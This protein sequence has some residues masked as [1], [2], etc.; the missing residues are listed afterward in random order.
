VTTQRFVEGDVRACYEFLAHC[1]RGVSEIRVIAPGRG[2]VGIGYFDNAD[3]FLRACAD[4]TGVGN[5]YVGIQPRPWEFLAQA[6]NRLERL[7]SG[8]RDEDIQW[9]S[10]IVIDIDPIRPK[11][12]AATSDELA[13][14]IACGDRI[15][16]WLASKGFQRPVRNMSGNGCQLWFAVPPTMITDEQRP[17]IRERLKLFEARLRDKF[18]GDGVAIDSIYNFSRIIKVIGTLSVKGE[19]TAE[20]PHRVSHSLDAFERRE[21]LELLEAIFRIPLPASSPSPSAEESAVTVRTADQL[22]PKLQALLSSKTR[23]R[24]LFEGRGKTAIGSDGTPL[25]TSSSGY[26]YSLALKLAQ[27]GI[28]DPDELA[29]VLWHRP[30]GEA[31]AKGLSYIERT[32]RHALEVAGAKRALATVAGDGSEENQLPLIQ[33]NNRQPR[34]ITIDARYAFVAGNARRIQEAPTHGLQSGGLPPM[35]LRGGHIV[36]LV[37]DGD[38][39]PELAET[40]DTAMLG[41]LWRDA[42]WINVTEGE[43]MATFP[44]RDIARDLVTF[45]DPSIPR[46]DIVLSTPVFGK[47]GTLITAPG[48]HA[49][50]ALWLEP[51]EGLQV[52]ELEREPTPEQVSHARQL[53]TEHLFVD[54]PFVDQADRAHG[55]AALLLPFVRRMIAGSTPLHLIEA[56]AVGSG[57]SLLCQLISIVATGRVLDASTLPGDEEEVRKTLTAELAKGSP[58]IL[59]DNAKERKVLD[60]SALASVLTAPTWRC[61]IL[62][63]SEIVIL[64]NSAMWMLTGNNPRLSVELTRRCVRIRIDPKR[65]RAWQRTGFKHDPITEWAAAHRAELVHAVLTLGQAWVAAGKPLAKQ[66]LGSFE[67][68]SAVMG[69]ILEVIGVPGFLGNL[70]DMYAE[71]DADGEMWR[72]FIS[73]WWESFGDEE[74]RVNELN[75]LCEQKNLM[76]PIRGDGAERAQQT[77]LGRALQ[78]ARD[79]VFDDVCLE[80]HRDKH[81]GRHYRLVP[82]TAEVES[83]N[84]SVDPWE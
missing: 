19:D 79:R 30:N 54:F 33:L 21:D 73:A 59:L 68:W 67:H 6:P 46:V 45:P 75:A 27:M 55:L 12:T 18:A 7:K 48:L 63:K 22:S 80:A 44:P 3:A 70:D 39:P 52:P 4:A 14:A 58:I 37:R 60:S 17:R 29:T 35:F 34:D 23:L 38:A 9:L 24:A 47:D 51:T 76:G 31:R 40:N 82:V 28:T 43:I 77:R 66:R 81:R 72:E 8:A 57:K 84:R 83:P 5:V 56:P 49:D 41:A 2:I 61:R 10:S 50:E 71:A 74:K 15:S 42:N 11:D 13:L 20:R 1:D 26:D 16:D 62:G 69:G 36:H 78:A 65:D 32:V 64:P 53:L 25:D